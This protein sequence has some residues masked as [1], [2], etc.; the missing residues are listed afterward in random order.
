ME[1]ATQSIYQVQRALM[2]ASGKSS[3]EHAVLLAEF[4][5]A[6]PALRH[7]WVSIKD[8]LQ[9]CAIY[10]EQYT[11]AHRVDPERLGVR[12]KEVSRKILEVEESFRKLYVELQTKR[13]PVSICC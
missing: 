7:E 11:D 9:R 6:R 13:H 2:N 8:L 5:K 1:D 3:T 12:A 10:A 4:K